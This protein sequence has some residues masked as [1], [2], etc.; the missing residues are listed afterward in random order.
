[1]SDAE[2]WVRNGRRLGRGA[3]AQCGGKRLVFTRD[4]Q[5]AQRM[6]IAAEHSQSHVTLEADFRPV[7]ATHQSVATLQS[8]DRGLHSPSPIAKKRSREMRQGFW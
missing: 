1:M 7:A 8:A 3:F 6:K 2:S 5:L 4:E